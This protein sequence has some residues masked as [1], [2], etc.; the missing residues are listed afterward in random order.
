MKAQALPDPPPAETLPTPTL[1]RLLGRKTVAVDRRP[2]LRRT[3]AWNPA[4]LGLPCAEVLNMAVS[5]NGFYS[6]DE[7]EFSLN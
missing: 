6:P 5:G 1:R 3:G 7:G 2:G 4:D